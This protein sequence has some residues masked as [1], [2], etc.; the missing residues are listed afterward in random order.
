LRDA[1][2]RVNPHLKVDGKAL[3]KIDTQ[4][5][6]AYIEALRSWPLAVLRDQ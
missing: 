2:R 6:E 4:Q 1:E 3:S 5:I